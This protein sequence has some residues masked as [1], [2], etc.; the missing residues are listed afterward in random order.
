M[1]SNTE[2]RKKLNELYILVGD[3][4]AEKSKEIPKLQM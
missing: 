1:E 3:V 2:M 4:K